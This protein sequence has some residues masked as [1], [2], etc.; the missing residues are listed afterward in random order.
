MLNILGKRERYCD[1]VSR[2]DFLQVGAATAVGVT[3]PGLLA[4]EAQAGTLKRRSIIN[5]YLG[6]G[7]TH[8]DTFD[9]KPEAPVEFRGEFNP[10][11]TNVPGM[12]ICEL[13]PKLAQNADKYAIIRSVTGVRNEHSARQSDSGWN[14]LALRAVGGRPGIGA[15]VGKMH[16][17]LNGLA[18]TSVSLSNFGNSGFLSSEYNPYRPDN[19][20]KANLRLN[21]SLSEERLG[22]RKN[23]LANLDRMRRD[24]DRTRSM[25][26]IDEFNERA[27]SVITSGELADALDISKEDPATLEAYGAN[28]RSNRYS[29]GNRNF[30]LARRLVQAG[31]RVVGLRWGG[32]DSHSKNFDTM[33]SQLP[34][35]DAGLTGLLTDLEQH[36][37]LEDTLVLMS[38]EFGRT[39]RI[40]SNAGRD[41]WPRAA[42]WF[43]AGG[44]LRT[45]Q[46]IGSTNRLGEAPQDRPVHLQEIYAT[47]YRQLGVDLSQ[48]I[49]D[50]AG[51]PQYILEHR[52][53]IAELV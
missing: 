29:S 26:S 14:E 13:M 47:V 21:R 25:T 19:V 6:G 12:E 41:H 51:R 17:T 40:N 45:G 30:V 46:V 22:G 8:M 50:P 39:P 49:M 36:G 43:V 20:G 23:L 9:L 27:I 10:I 33:R 3:L 16:G 42:F 31:V 11:K 34:A 53:P 28:D 37:M 32:W 24:V 7:P 4:A 15:V 44:G 2:R 48:T 35:L 1:G 52:D 5:I 38:G 18:P